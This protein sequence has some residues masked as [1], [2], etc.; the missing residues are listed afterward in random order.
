MH[1]YCPQVQCTVG[2]SSFRKEL[3]R[4][5]QPVLT[6]ADLEPNKGNLLPKGGCH[7]FWFGFNF[8]FTILYPIQKLLSSPEVKDHLLHLSLEQWTAAAA[9]A[10]AIALKPWATRAALFNSSW[11]VTAWEWVV[12]SPEPW[13]PAAAAAAVE[14]P[15]GV[16]VLSNRDQSSYFKL[17]SSFP[18]TLSSSL[19]FKVTT[20]VVPMISYHGYGGDLY[21]VQPWWWLW[22]KRR[23]QWPSICW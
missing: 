12:A 7:I 13:T 2:Y 9:L 11:A 17:S 1:L 19:F 10:V 6:Q 18:Q 14:A 20:R 8:F 21:N 4:T 3:C 5:C 22:W 16:F 23:W 15:C